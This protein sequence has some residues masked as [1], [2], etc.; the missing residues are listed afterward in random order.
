MY[1]AADLIPEA[2]YR[3][4]SVIVNNTDWIDQVTRQGSMQNYHL[5]ISGGSENSNYSVS[6]GYFD[7]KGVVIKSHLKRYTPQGQLRLQGRE[8]VSCRNI[9][10]SR[11]GLR[12]SQ[13]RW[14]IQ[15]GLPDLTITAGL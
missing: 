6:A 2:I 12:G 5:S 1:A 10:F 8:K 9:H 13:R 7:Q 11:K 4:S 15:V 3:D 14:F